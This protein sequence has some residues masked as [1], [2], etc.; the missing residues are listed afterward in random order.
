MSDVISAIVGDATQVCIWPKVQP[1]GDDS[2]HDGPVRIRNIVDGSG[3][4]HWLAL[5]DG[6]ETALSAHYITDAATW[7]PSTGGVS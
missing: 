1:V 6:H 2:P 7:Q 4:Q 3:D 5:C